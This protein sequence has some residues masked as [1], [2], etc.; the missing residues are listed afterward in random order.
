[1]LIARLWR[2]AELLLLDS[3]TG[4]PNWSSSSSNLFGI[5]E[6]LGYDLIVSHDCGSVI[7]KNVAMRIM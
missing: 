2:P 1:V 3:T 5:E 4:I 7:E 6:E